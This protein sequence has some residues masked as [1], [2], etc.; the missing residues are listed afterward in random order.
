MNV[1]FGYSKKKHV[2][3]TFIAR[4]TKKKHIFGN[5]RPIGDEKQNN[6]IILKFYVHFKSSIVDLPNKKKCTIPF[7]GSLHH[8]YFTHMNYAVTR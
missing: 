6:T 5:T 3:H 1:Y 8:Y 4:T 2:V 7:G